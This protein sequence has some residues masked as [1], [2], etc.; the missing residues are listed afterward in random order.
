MKFFSSLKP[1]YFINHCTS[2]ANDGILCSNVLYPFFSEKLI[3]NSESTSYYQQTNI[4]ATNLH[5]FKIPAAYFS[6]IDFEFRI[7]FEVDINICS[8]LTP[9]RRSVN[10]GLSRN[11]YRRVL[12]RFFRL[13]NV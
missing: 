5:N 1:T 6:R 4:Q 13:C 7:S 11:A 8:V 9:R 10:D 2:D 3:S 12:F